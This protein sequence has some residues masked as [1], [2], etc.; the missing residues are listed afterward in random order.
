M[1]QHR[2]PS[3]STAASSTPPPKRRR[4]AS[5]PGEHTTAL[6]V[7]S[8]RVTLAPLALSLPSGMAGF[9]SHG[10]LVD[11]PCR[12]TKVLT[13]AWLSVVP[14]VK[15]WIEIRGR[16]QQTDTSLP[17]L[18]CTRINTLRQQVRVGTES[19]MRSLMRKVGVDESVL[20]LRE[21]QLA[22][23]PPGCG[24]QKPHYDI[25]DHEAA[26]QSYVII[27]YCTDTM[28]T[29]VSVHS[30]AEMRFTFTEGEKPLSQKALSIVENTSSFVSRPVDAGSALLM[31]CVSLHHGI[32]NMR[33]QDRIVV[34][35][36]FVPK[37][38]KRANALIMRYPAGAP[39]CPSESKMAD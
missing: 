25:E 16:M 20:T 23:S 9:S 17:I 7:G 32:E 4:V 18:H 15:E 39:V 5:D 24:L 10:W 27:L 21:M 35:G 12:V 8:K 34:F 13:S 33:P 3:S 30:L 14:Q 2:P 38:L 19:W 29:A 1:K 37:T 11:A 31:R 6:V 26:S 22:L 36:L 28:S